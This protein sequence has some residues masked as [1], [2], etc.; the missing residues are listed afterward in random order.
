M[1]ALIVIRL[2]RVTDATTSPERQLQTCRELCDNRG[3][4][5]VGVAEDLDV[6]AG[7]TTP[8]DRPQIGDWLTNRLG[9]FDVLVFFRADRIV[10][11]LFDLADLIRWAR[12]HSVTLVSATESYFDLSSD[13]GDIIALL[14][15]KVAE[16]ELAAIS[17]RNSSAAR[18][19][20]RAGKYRGG[21]P[22]WGYLPQQTEEGW[23]YVQDPEQVPV[24]NEVVRRTLEGEPLRA[25]AHDLTERGVLTPRDRFAQFQGRE[26]KDYEWHSGPLKRSLTSPT[27]MG[28]VVAREALADAQGRVQRD[29]KGKKVFGPDAVV[30]ADDG[31]PV[32]RS[33]PILTREV[34][35]R[36]AIELSGRENRKE[37]TKRSTGLLL[38]IVHCGI[39]ERPAYRLKGGT[40]RKPRY[41]CSSAQYKATCGNK[42]ISLEYADETV[43]TLL[44]GMLGESERLDRLWDKG[45]DHSAELAEI[46]DQLMDFTGLLGTGPY[47]AGTPQ[48]VK[49]NHRITQLAARQEELSSQTVKPSGWTWQPTGEKFGDW[50]ERQDVTARNVWLRSMGIRLEFEFVADDPS[51]KLRLDLGDLG[52]LT[53]QLNASGPAAQWQQMFQAMGK[54][55]AGVELGGDEAVFV[56]T[57]GQ[58]VKSSDL[59]ASSQKGE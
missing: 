15:A 38:Q 29:G 50:W 1:R 36:L 48:R 49:L 31:S 42:S 35:D 37:P 26:V 40:G 7:S 22:P 30:R 53:E 57:D 58:R 20:I 25:I 46:N 13:F 8:F 9:E 34:F 39:C 59:N 11:R 16:M 17:E 43:E 51:P 14:V 6:S 27:L 10:R 5:V 33:E 28:H 23:R 41:R 4:E 47:K 18:Y 3:Y 56:R 54:D 2:S 55:I 52:T 44:L 12:D 32:V 45:S 24:I 21:T 19:N